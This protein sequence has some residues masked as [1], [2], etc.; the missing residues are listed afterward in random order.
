MDKRKTKQFLKTHDTSGLGT[1]DSYVNFLA[2]VGIGASNLSAGSTYEFNPISRNR[3][4]IE[5]M[6]RGSW[7]VGQV[8]DCVADDM[9]R[10]GI[11]IA[12]TMPPDD[13]DKLQTAMQELCVWTKLNE[14]IKWARLYGGSLAVLLVDGQKPETP[15]R[16]DTIGK[17]Q[18]K[19]LMILD[20]WMVQ[21]N[22]STLV[23]EFGPDL[24][25]PKFYDVVADAPALPRMRIHY[26]RILRMD[27][28]VLPYFQKLYENLWGMSVLERLYDRMTAFD[29]ATLGMAQL[30]YKAHLRTLSIDNLRELIAAG[31]QQYDSVVKMINAIRLLQSNE[32][33]TVIDA[34]DK[35]ETHQYTFSGLSD[36]ILQLGQQLSGAVQIPLVRLFGQSPAGLNSTGES[37][38]RNYYDGIK[39]QQEGRLRRSLHKLLQVMMRSL[40]IPEPADFGFK[41][42]PLWQLTEQD[43]ADVAGKVYT[44]VQG[45]IDGGLIS[46]ATGLKELRQ[47]SRITGV[48]SNITDDDIE[49]AENEAPDPSE[50]AGM[51]H[52]EL[53]D[54]VAGKAK[55]GIGA[56]EGERTEANESG[57]PKIKLDG[58]TMGDSTNTLPLIEVHDL[59]LMIETPK[60]AIRRGPGWETKMPCDYGFIRATGSAEGADE[61]LDCFVGPDRDSKRVWIIDQYAGDRFDEHKVMLGFLNKSAALA[62]YDAAFSDGSGPSRRRFVSACSIDVLREWVDNGDVTMPYKDQES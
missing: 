15:L 58:Q 9:T 39:E 60:G 48:F 16:I 22:L 12:S 28:V 43:K 47:N 54:F 57:D 29:S 37:D 23:T 27:G 5:W 17:G 51:P 62:A 3:T 32:G 56:P 42:V 45:A 36:V 13:I 6:Y 25:V 31:G 21:P 26:S 10:E 44:T 34:S 35:F 61:Q 2:N 33:M 1:K 4:L 18:F 14:N 40:T 59:Q 11:E 41:F 53:A 49:D 7:L 30:V 55:S 20:R 8:V 50:M 24:G 46:K 19:G 38:I 52:Q